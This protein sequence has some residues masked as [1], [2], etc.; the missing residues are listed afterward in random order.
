MKKT[1]AWLARYALEQLGIKHTFGIP[2]VHNTELY[3]ELNNSE[4]I[5][6]HLVTHEVSAAF[7]A[8]AV[9]R[10]TSSLGT[11][12]IV[13]AAGLTH[14]MSGIGEAY[15]DGIGMLVITGGINRS[16]GK[17]YQLHQIDQLELTKGITKAG[18]RIE[19]HNEIVATLFR[20]HRIATSGKPGPVLVELPVDIQLFKGEVKHLPEFQPLSTSQAVSESLL[21][22]AAD[23]LKT[24]KKPAMFVGWGAKNARSEVLALAERFNMPIATTLQ[25]L[26]VVPSDHPLHVGMSFGRHAVPAAEQAFADCD[27]LVAIGTCFSEIPTGSYGITVPEQLIH[28]DIDEAVFDQNYPAKVAICA[29][30]KQAVSQLNQLAEKLSIGAQHNQQIQN[31]IEQAKQAYQQEWRELATD[32][33]NP[34]ALFSQLD[35]AL[36]QDCLFVVDD[37]NHTFLTAELM[38][39]SQQRSFISPTDFNCMGYAVPAAIGAKIANPDRQVV[40]VVGDGAFM[41]TCMEL[42]TANQHELGLVYFV[43][44]DGELSQISQGQEIPY[45]RKTCTQLGKVDFSGIAQATGS[46]YLRINNNDEINDVVEQALSLMK[47]HKTVIVDVAIEYSKRTRFTQGVVKTNVERF[48]LQDKLRIVSR[49]LTRKITG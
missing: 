5:T 10:T 18:F 33:V 2:G 40:S 46:H 29:D 31:N 49:A 39:F 45:N 21:N 23:L 14:A 48:P 35:S 27:C 12:V 13:P 15:L 44:N 34:A 24:A 38:P 7:M 20:A 30:A 25:G 1:G 11:L 16:T 6:P 8:D 4:M 26:S 22:Q 32:R 17:Q 47:T 19:N 36:S 28:I 9:T 42:V 41:M 37:G 43:F 3:D